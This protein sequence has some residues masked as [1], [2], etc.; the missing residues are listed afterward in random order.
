MAQTQGQAHASSRQVRARR[1]TRSLPRGSV[2]KDHTT[3]TW[4]ELS[5]FQMSRF[6]TPTH[7]TMHQRS[8]MNQTVRPDEHQ[9]VRCLTSYAQPAWLTLKSVSTHHLTH[10]S[11]K[12][13]GCSHTNNTAPRTC[14][15][16]RI[17]LTFRLLKGPTSHSLDWAESFVSFCFLVVSGDL[18]SGGQSES[19][20]ARAPSCLGSAS[21]RPDQLAI[22]RRPQ[23]AT[24]WS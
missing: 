1:M 5:K 7:S 24:L 17:T 11:K 16:A 4:S 6:H 9:T 21:V 18:H 8:R 22:V 20:S 12:S 2:W 13:M 10:A 23:S 15:S 19:C 14:G 3:R